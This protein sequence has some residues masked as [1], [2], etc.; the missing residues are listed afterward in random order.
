MLTM[1]Q[2]L[3]SHAELQIQIKFDDLQIK[4]IDTETVCKITDTDKVRYS[5]MVNRVT[6]KDEGCIV[7]V[8]IEFLELQI[9]IRILRVIGCTQSSEYRYKYFNIVIYYRA[10]N[11]NFG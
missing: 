11:G 6:D 4:L 7:T 1:L 2:I 10:K 9:Q 8:H 5:F 3:I